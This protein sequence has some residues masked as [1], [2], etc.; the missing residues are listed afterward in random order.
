MAAFLRSAGEVAFDR[1]RVLFETFGDSNYIGEPVSIIEHSLQAAYFTAQKNKDD[2]ELIIANL[3]HDIGHAL[4]LEVKQAMEMNGCGVKDHEHVGADF[5]LKLGFPARVAQLARSHVQA[6]RFL[7][8]QKPDYYSNL[9]E[10]SKTTL[11][12]QGGPM[13]V[14]EAAAFENDPDFKNI[15]LMRECDEAG[16]V[17]GSQ[18]TVPDFASYREVIK[19]MVDASGVVPSGYPL[20]EFQIASFKQNSFLKLDNLLNFDK[21]SASDV[22]NWCEE[23]AKWPKAEN[24][25]LLHWE[26]NNNGEK[27]MCRSENFVNYHEGM[28]HLARQCVL[29]VVSQLFNDPA[30]TA[31]TAATAG[32]AVLFKEKINYKLVG[33]AGFAAHQDSPAYIGLADDH[34][35]VMVAVDDA[36]EQ[37]GCLQ[38]CPGQW[39]KASNVPLTDAG[40]VTPE[41]EA[42]M[43]F[44]P[45]PCTAGDILFFNGYIPHRSNANLSDKNRRAV[46]LT[47]NPLCQGDHHA[48][49]YAAKHANVQGFDGAHAIS[50]Q[51]DFQGKIVD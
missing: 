36:T 6:K 50:F 40:I 24:K 38:V 46:F 16:K 20:S 45:V 30:P 48:A 26:L 47:Y 21:V 1:L 31:T 14:E 25:W 17:P 4:G 3:L 29:S 23:I 32:G 12:F 27:I 51:G 22:S 42:K 41:A 10:A 28:A 7:C 34:I 9:S 44:I 13:N 49:Y 2:Q 18:I 33:G 11:G 15:L 35:S 39:G 5:L 43:S 8:F 19:T 37:N